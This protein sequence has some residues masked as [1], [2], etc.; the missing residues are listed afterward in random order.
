MSERTEESGWNAGH[1]K[2]RIQVPLSRAPAP[3]HLDVWR[4]RSGSGSRAAS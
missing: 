2:G 1:Q 3:R 4:L